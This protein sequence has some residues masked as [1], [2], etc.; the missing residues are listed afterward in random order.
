MSVK[1][2]GD[3]GFQNHFT[4]MGSCILAPH[5]GETGARQHNTVSNTY[6]FLRLY[7][8]KMTWFHWI[9]QECAFIQR[10]DTVT[11]TSVNGKKENINMNSPTFNLWSI[12]RPVCGFLWHYSQDV[13]SLGWQIN[14]NIM[15]NVFTNYCSKNEKLSLL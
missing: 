9:A 12:L 6:S 7:F 10:A 13:W 15:Q 14:T 8:M 5:S 11:W 1:I 4:V 2:S 3:P